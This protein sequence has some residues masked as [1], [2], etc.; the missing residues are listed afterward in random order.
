M[1]E[2]NSSTGYLTDS[3]SKSLL[4]QSEEALTDDQHENF[5][6]VQSKNS[7]IKDK[8][9]FA[10]S[11]EES[12][13]Y[14]YGSHDDDDE[15]ETEN[16]GS[17]G[18]YQTTIE[19]NVESS[20][21]EG[22]EE[23]YQEYEFKGELEEKPRN[24]RPLPTQ[25]ST[26]RLLNSRN[27]TT[28]SPTSESDNTALVNLKK[29]RIASSI[30]LVDDEQVEKAEVD[31]ITGASMQVHYEEGADQ[32]EDFKTE[33]F[34]DGHED[35]K[36]EDDQF[37][38]SREEERRNPLLSPLSSTFE[39]MQFQMQQF[40]ELMERKMDKLKGDLLKELHS[41]KTPIT[42]LKQ[43][44]VRV[45]LSPKPTR[46]KPITTKSEFDFSP[47][48][49]HIT[50]KTSPIHERKSENDEENKNDESH[51]E[52]SDEDESEDSE[53][54]PPHLKEQKTKFEAIF[55]DAI[56]KCFGRMRE[57][58]GLNQQ[59]NDA[60]KYSEEA[61]W[62][63]ELYLYLKEENIHLRDAL[64]IREAQITLQ[65]KSL[66]NLTKEN[67]EAFFTIQ[68]LKRKLAF[69]TRLVNKYLQ[70][71]PEK[72]P[73]DESI[74]IPQILD[75]MKGLE[76]GNRGYTSNYS[77]SNRSTPWN[78]PGTP[79]GQ[80]FGDSINSRS[81]LSPRPG[82]IPLLKSSSTAS[83]LSAIN[84]E[85][86]I[87]NQFIAQQSPINAQIS[88]NIEEPSINNSQNE[89]IEN[90][91]AAP[92]QVSSPLVS[93]RAQDIS[94]GQ[95]QGSFS[96]SSKSPNEQNRRKKLSI[97]TLN[98]NNSRSI[99]NI[100]INPIYDENAS[101]TEQK[102]MDK[103]ASRLIKSLKQYPTT[104]D[105]APLVDEKVQ[106]IQKQFESNGQEIPLVRIGD[107]YYQLGRR[108]LNLT[109][110]GNQIVVKTGGGTQP[111]LTFLKRHLA[112]V[113]NI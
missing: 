70:K 8:E 83:G 79:R 53:E 23:E 106:Q 81:S 71:K 112:T 42:Q 47:R 65:Q 97:S 5:V 100:N 80:G 52:K 38:N 10:E 7:D 20:D 98:L 35:F 92:N 64:T 84:T 41:N 13:P 62:L 36:T 45:E 54:L 57:I 67:K 1:T 61:K 6:D 43:E 46:S 4:S 101:E 93:P 104:S 2:V 73:D 58:L 48:G 22:Y 111:L 60:W 103:L 31:S 33:D 16:E 72:K 55:E 69:Q 99:E 91:L 108:K 74:L 95:V 88:S 49:V 29:S 50:T 19:N 27:S 14:A 11:D 107:C 75:K 12:D 66:Q 51:S 18:T 28:Q 90:Q 9:N 25:M 76:G 44:I 109:L 86:P 32:E 37:N 3:E 15:T 89:I 34:E 85:S 39:N 77:D 59:N 40:E 56:S 113:R 110:A 78:T 17:Q 94:T 82:R 26:E 21:S 87:H 102:I 105:L 96:P 30:S 63:R 68:E 24:F